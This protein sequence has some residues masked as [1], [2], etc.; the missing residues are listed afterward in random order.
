MRKTILIL[1][2]LCLTLSLFSGCGKPGGSAYVPTGNALV[3]EDGSSAVEVTEIPA[4]EEQELTLIYYEE[5]T[6]NPFTC[7]DFTNRALFPL[8]YQSLFSVDRNYQVH[9][10]LCKQYSVSED[11]TTYTFYIED[12]VRFA[13]GSLLT[14]QDVVASF[15]T[16]L[17]SPMYQ[18][19]FNFVYDVY[20]T[21]DKGIEV[22]LYHAYENFP[23]LLDFPIVKSGEVKAEHPAGTGPYDLQQ[24]ISGPKLIRK[25]NWWCQSDLLVTA[26]SINLIKAESNNQ[27]RDQFEFADLDLVCADPGSDYYADYRCDYEVWECENGIFLYLA[28]N[29]ESKVFDS[30][31]MRASLTYAIDRDALVENYYR[32]YARAASLPASPLSPYYS[33]SLAQRYEYNAL[34]FA[35]MV[36][37][38]GQRNAEITLLVNNGDSLRLRVARAIAT[39]L[40]ESGMKVTLVERSGYEYEE[41]LNWGE[42]DLYLGQTQLSKNMDLSQFFFTW[43]ALRYGGIDDEKLYE[44]CLDALSNSG[45]YYPLHQQIM[46]TGG[47]CPI[48]FRSYAVFATRG[49]L[50]ELQPARDNIFF[51]TVGKTLDSVYVP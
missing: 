5:R 46:D 16:A 36:S 9:P 40:E 38:A 18:G 49:M 1:L 20:L 51:Y 48:L 22:I 37:S 45:N 10:I 28:Y 17:D 50:T 35:E 26:S 24:T 25:A 8:L 2:V 31:T 6:M 43:G 13:D 15:R 30:Q 19:R 42:Y 11:M 44:L 7:S 33:K 14:P 29:S 41:Y 12:N 3:M 34:K 39:M 4:E 27:I 23:L 32:G 21:E 47:I